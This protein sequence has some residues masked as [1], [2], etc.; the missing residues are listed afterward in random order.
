MESTID[1][2]DVNG[3]ILASV[4]EIDFN[5]SLKSLLLV[6]KEALLK[7]SIRVKSNAYWSFKNLRI[8]TVNNHKISTGALLMYGTSS[9][10]EYKLVATIKPPIITLHEPPLPHSFVKG[11]SDPLIT[12]LMKLLNKQS[13][14]KQ[15]TW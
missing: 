1:V 11:I 10:K 9:N 8:V 7:K 3:Q 6:A 4:N 13:S 12:S 14:M 2:L 5:N 15:I